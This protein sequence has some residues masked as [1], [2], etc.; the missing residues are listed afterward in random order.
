MSLKVSGI[1]HVGIAVKALETSIPIFESL[2]GV[3]CY[4][5][6]DVKSQNVRTAFFDVGG[7]KIELLESM[8]ETSSIEKFINKRGEGL[9]HIA[10]KVENTD[11]ALEEASKLGFDLIDSSSR[12]GA[13]NLK[14]GF[15]DPS[16]TNKVLIEL[17]SK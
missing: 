3:K 15:I 4:K 14:I 16:S 5:I 10:L 11:E 7:V 13:D 9:H 2:L 12:I 17:T 1:E 8:S 6:E